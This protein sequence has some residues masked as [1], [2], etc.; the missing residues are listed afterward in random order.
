[1]FEVGEMDRSEYYQQEGYQKGFEDAKR[2][3]GRITQENIDRYLNAET[4]QLTAAHSQEFI[5]GWYKGFNDGAVEA[6]CKLTTDS[7]FW[8]NHIYW[9]NPIFKGR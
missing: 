1:M 3:G 6:A 7:N 2:T 8:K 9:E 4:R 5:E